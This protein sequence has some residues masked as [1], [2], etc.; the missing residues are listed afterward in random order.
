[1]S[2]SF[3][4]Q[5][6]TAAKT[7]SFNFGPAAS[8]G[9]LSFGSGSTNPPAATVQPLSAPAFGLSSTTS[10]TTGVVAPTLSFGQPSLGST[11]QKPAPLS[12]SSTTQ[13]SLNFGAPAAQPANALSTGTSLSFGA[14]TSSI[15][16]S[17][18]AP[19]TSFGLSTSGTQNKIAPTFGAATGQTLGSSQPSLLGGIGTAS[20]AATGSF[21]LGTTPA[22]T[23]NVALGLGGSIAPTATTT[24]AT[25][26]VGLGGTAIGGISATSSSSDPKTGGKAIKETAIPNE[27]VTAVEDFKKFVKEERGVSSDIA[28]VSPKIHDKISEE[29]DGLSRLVTTLMSGL[30]RNRLVLDKLK[31]EAAQELINAEIAQRT[32]DTPPGLQYENVAPFE[33]FER[34]MNNFENQMLHYRRQIEETEQHLQTMASGRILAPE[35]VTR[36]LQKLHTAFIGLAGRYHEIHETVKMQAETYVQW[37]R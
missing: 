1:M 16:S 3:G 29:V 36:A 8:S 23:S 21:N 28:H 17:Q 13:P 5:T 33:Y 37:H 14:N 18:V 7:P 25:A 10:A 12:F 26:S 2:F 11:A 6:N 24:V 20:T 27:L 19:G 22:Q 4:A 30:S 15:S 35:D 9:G 34:L 32:K 31:K